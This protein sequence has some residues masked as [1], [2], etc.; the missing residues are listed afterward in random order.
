M[1]FSGWLLQRWIVRLGAACLCLLASCGV[2]VLVWPDA[3]FKT[4]DPEPIRVG[5]RAV[6]ITPE[7]TDGLM[8]AGGIP[9]RWISAVHDDLWARA[10]V[11]DDGT[12]RVGLVSLDLIGLDYEDVNL[13][14]MDVAGRVDVD[15]LLIACTHTHSAPD[16]MGFWSPGPFV[17]DR[18][19]RQFVGQRVADA[20]VGAVDDLRAARLRVG[21][22]YSASA[23]YPMSK[24]TRVPKLIDDVLAVWQAVDRETGETIATSVHYAT[25]PITVP[26]ML[27]EVSSDFPHYLRE[28]IETGRTAGSKVIQGSGGVCLYFNGALGGRVTP[29]ASILADSLP[30]HPSYERARDFGVRLAERA[31]HVLENE[32]E[33]LDERLSISVRSRA[34]RIPLDNGTMMAMIFG[35]VLE[36]AMDQG[37][38]DSEVAMIDIGPI[39]FFAVP[40]MIFPELTLGGAGPLPGSDFPDAPIEEPPLYELS[41]KRYPIVI[42]LANDLLGNIIPKSMWDKDGPFT[43]EDR[44]APYGEVISPGCDTA[45]VV[46]RAFADL[47]QD[48]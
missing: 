6:A 45:P 43:T 32:G 7:E 11:F 2:P 22:G 17:F 4:S 13:I 27:T 24:D 9:F 48:Q 40:G 41:S 20:V 23:D 5:A 38:L 42:G 29:N 46:M 37:H 28:T 47:Q 30:I 34:I 8:L 44:S 25:H 14:R 16:L 35:G 1:H 18:P 10:V 21:R 31:V 3:D 26:S 36:R 12:H 33:E 19:Y 39:Q 15:Y